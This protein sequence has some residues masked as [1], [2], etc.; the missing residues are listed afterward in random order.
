MAITPTENEAFYR[1]VDEELR[2]EQIAK[3]WSRY[4]TYVILG[5]ILLI[6]AIG[7]YFYWQ[8]RQEVKAGETAEQLTQ[9][10]EEIQKGNA[11]QALPKLDAIAAE[12]QPGYRAAALMTKADIALGSG[13][14]A[15]AIAAFKAIAEDAKLAD[16]Y[17][18]LALIR[19]TAIEYDKLQP[20]V[21]IARLKA[22]AAP[23]NPWFGSAGEMVAVAHLKK[24]QP[25]QA[26]PIFAAMAADQSLPPSIRSRAVQ[27]ASAL[28]I[29][30]TSGF[31]EGETKEA[32]Q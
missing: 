6:A 11:K 23:G 20:D 29:D 1:E 26:A 4:G 9:T 16:P 24:N 10:F 27:M 17:R 3:G 8:H 12:G 19:Q 28:G 25:R 21:V 14:E 2:R 15:G 22:L 32:K 30:A 5:I 31:G 13:D 7:A 18:N